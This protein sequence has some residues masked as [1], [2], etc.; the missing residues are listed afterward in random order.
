M[1]ASPLLLDQADHVVYLDA[2]EVV[3]EGSHREL[4]AAVP[5]YAHTVIRGED[6]Q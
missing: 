6:D 2:G 3:A 4:L 5:A 1:T